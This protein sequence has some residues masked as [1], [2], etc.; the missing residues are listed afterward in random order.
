[1]V[2]KS[3]LSPKDIRDLNRSTLKLNW[4]EYNRES[5]NIRNN[6]PLSNHSRNL[7]ACSYSPLICLTFSSLVTDLSLACNEN[8]FCRWIKRRFCELLARQYD[9]NWKHSVPEN[10]TKKRKVNN[11][12]L[13]WY[14][15][16]S[17]SFSFLFILSS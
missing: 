16:I 4:M 9:S 7:A 11:I 6:K 12:L 13:S 3:S 14:L 10:S 1:M 2:N 5:K 15:L 8:Q 17:L